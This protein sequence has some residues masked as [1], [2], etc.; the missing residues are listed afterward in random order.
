MDTDFICRFCLSFTQLSFPIFLE[1]DPDTA[2]DIMNC[3]QIKI[4]KDSIGPIFI[5]NN[6]YDQVHNWVMFKKNSDEVLQNIHTI[7]NSVKKKPVS[8]TNEVIDLLDEED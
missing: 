1:S 3:L 6:C 4:T 5:C 8:T 2:R 7:I